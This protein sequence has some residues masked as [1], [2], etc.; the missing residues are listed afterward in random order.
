M[1]SLK[2]FKETKISNTN[3]LKGGGITPTEGGER[4]TADGGCISYGSD[5]EVSLFGATS[6][7]YHDTCNVDKECTG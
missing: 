1:L 6:T 4:C 2:D 7:I 3:S 5:T